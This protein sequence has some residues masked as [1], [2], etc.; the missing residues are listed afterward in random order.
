MYIHKSATSLPY[1]LSRWGRKE[2]KG[3]SCLKAWEEWELVIP[4]I[5]VFDVSRGPANAILDTTISGGFRPTVSHLSE[6]FS[7]PERV[8]V[9]CQVRSHLRRDRGIGRRVTLLLVLNRGLA[10]TLSPFPCS[11]SFLFQVPGA[12]PKLAWALEFQV[13]HFG[14]PVPEVRTHPRNQLLWPGHG[15]GTS[16]QLPELDESLG[17]SGH[18][19]C[20]AFGT[21]GG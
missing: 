7:V 20:G 21:E 1:L 13:P 2:S 19:G 10:S 15:T 17:T 3:S 18:G 16:I 14:L 6:Y 11:Y 5:F 12:V 8:L 9:K 4:W